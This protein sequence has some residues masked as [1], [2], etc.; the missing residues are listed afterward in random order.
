MERALA[1]APQSAAHT[2]GR[3]LHLQRRCACGAKAQPQQ[4]ECESCKA[5]GLQR[6]LAVG[7]S[8]DPF[9]READTVAARVLGTGQAQLSASPPVLRRRDD[10]TGQ[11]AC[12]QAVP[13]IVEGVLRTPGQALDRPSRAFFEPRFGRDFSQ[14]RVHHDAMAARS[15]DAVN[16]RA[17]TAGT[18]LVFASGQHVPDSAAG[19]ELLAHELAHVVQQA[20]AAPLV[21]R[22]AADTPTTPSPLAPPRTATAEEQKQIETAR[23]AALARTEQALNASGNVPEISIDFGERKRQRTRQL[24][25]QLFAPGEVSPEQVDRALRAIV[26]NLRAPEVRV[27]AAGDA[28]CGTRAGYVAGLA[29]PVVLC[30]AFFSD[31]PEQRIRTMIHEAAHLSGIGDPSTAEGYCPIY[32][33][34]G[35]CGGPESADAWAHF[36]HCLSG[37]AAD[38]LEQVT[39][40]S[41]LEPEARAAMESASQRKRLADIADRVFEGMEGL[42]TD[43]EGV[44]RALQELDR[45]PAQISDLMQI[46]AER[47]KPNKLL[48]DLNDDFS[49]SELEFALQL[50]N[51]GERDTPQ[52]I[53]KTSAGDPEEVARRIHEAVEGAGT[54]EEAIFA[55]LLPFRRDTLMLQRAYQELFDEDLRDRLEDELQEEQ[56]ELDYALDL[57]ET[58]FE[59]YLNEAS[60]W[61]RRYPAVGFGLPWGGK[62]WYDERFWRVEDAP[63]TKAKG[64]QDEPDEKM[65]VLKSGAPHEAIDA[66]FH[67]Q[68]RW[69]VDCSV[70]AEVVQLYALRQS[71]GAKRFDARVADTFALREGPPAEA[72][73]LRRHG[74]TGVKS[75]LLFKRESATAEFTVTG[76]GPLAAVPPVEQVLAEAPIGS[77]VR[78]TSQLLFDRWENPKG[79]DL[80][81]QGREEYPVWSAYQH[82]NALKL[83]PDRYAAQGVGGGGRASRQH[84]EDVLTEIT[85]GAFPKRSETEIR[86]N[87]YISE[88]EIFDQ[89]NLSEQIEPGAENSEKG[90]RP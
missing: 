10:A 18:H 76:V 8:D 32:D 63:K 86:A 54:D 71:L 49:G 27:A 40:E 64:K 77:R 33:C 20:G 82:E 48:D 25:A 55:A 83:G 90:P 62:G 45:D 38:E 46:Y 87:I 4:D 41:P 52:S 15:A 69:H 47:H 72:M 37:Q 88:I 13:A 84:I 65:L 6:R 89:P 60:S 12:G 66:L 51:L 21:Q 19:R 61:L 31:S 1:A 74:S 57:M 14:V 59:R 42:G 70:F 30:P 53:E 75:Q 44:Y 28:S 26:S 24:A 80:L 67:E 16:A 56:S 50:I 5:T 58:P 81:A 36:I 35:V 68:E 43:E 7:A 23:E 3:P 79:A 11:G 85:T 22:Q 39:P 29:P 34:E 78:W 9:E 73:E 2:A 17:Y